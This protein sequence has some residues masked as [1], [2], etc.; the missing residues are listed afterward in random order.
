[1]APISSIR[2][3]KDYL[4]SIKNWDAYS[5]QEQ[6]QLRKWYRAYYSHNKEAERKRYRDYYAANSE[7][8]KERVKKYNKPKQSGDN[9]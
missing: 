1:M 8:E 4:Q 5:S 3:Y 9:V 6:D 7:A 2:N